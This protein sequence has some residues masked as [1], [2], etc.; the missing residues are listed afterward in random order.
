MVAMRQ[1]IG[2]WAQRE[3]SPAMN[4]AAPSCDLVATQLKHLE[5]VVTVRSR[6]RH[7]DNI[8]NRFND[9]PGEDDQ[10]IVQ[11]GPWHG[12]VAELELGLG[13]QKPHIRVRPERRQLQADSGDGRGGQDDITVIVY[14]HCSDWGNSS[15]HFKVARRKTRQPHM[16]SKEDMRGT[17]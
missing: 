2:L 14:D 9:F 13:L 4:R 10:D 12:D 1:L 6:C 3:V 16:P 15:L 8:C 11:L 5:A 17:R 7:A